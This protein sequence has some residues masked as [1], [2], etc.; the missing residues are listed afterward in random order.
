MLAL[1]TDLTNATATVGSKT[2]SVDDVF[3]EPE[4]GALKYLS[5]ET[6]GWL[7]PDVV[8]ISAGLV[9]GYN[10]D[11]RT[12]DLRVEEDELKT[13][14]KIDP[15][16]ERTGVLTALPPI[17]VGPFGGTVSP[18]MATAAIAENQAAEVASE[19]HRIALP[20]VERTSEWIGQPVFGT[21]GELG[22]LSDLLFDPALSAVTHIVVDDGGLFNGRN[23]VLPLETVRHRG[24][25]DGHIVI[26]AS[27]AQCEKAPL[28]EDVAKVD[29][30][31]L[32]SLR[33]HFGVSS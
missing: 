7:D 12:I 10:R 25:K 19:R 28:L 23:V 20:G 14:R 5:L 30:G 26:R 6:G 22:L 32:D 15:A 1:I 2:V 11:D 17:V 27:H 16:T 3:F 29:R 24:E 33:H 18:M 21:D 8:L 4:T 9:A 31:W 13:A